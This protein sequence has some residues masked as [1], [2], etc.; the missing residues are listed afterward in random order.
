MF[1]LID[2]H[3][4]SKQCLPPIL[5]FFILILSDSFQITAFLP[6]PAM[7]IKLELDTEKSTKAAV[8]IT[9]VHTLSRVPTLATTELFLNVMPL[10]KLYMDDTGRFP[11]RARLGNQYIMIAYHADGNL[12]LQQSFK[13]KG[14]VHRLAAYNSIMTRLATNHGQ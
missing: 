2:S 3:K 1:V 8:A 4:S 9:T 7:E 14:D 11:V 12:I 10:S 13:T 5:L 6:P